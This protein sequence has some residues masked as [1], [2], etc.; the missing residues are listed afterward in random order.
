MKKFGLIAVAAASVSIA[1]CATNPYN[2]YGYDNNRDVRR[3]ATGAAI[4]G[5]GGAAIGAIVPGVSPVEGAI[6]G[7]VAG[8]VIGA[9]TDGNRRYYRDQRG[10]YF[11]DQ[12][13]YRRYDYNARC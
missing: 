8:G 4:G 10:C 6:A 2:Q 7:A 3:A 12:Q 5:A 11:V 1:G 13:G 9:V